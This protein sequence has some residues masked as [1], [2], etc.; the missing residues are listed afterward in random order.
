MFILFGVYFWAHLGSHSDHS[1]LKEGYEPRS[2]AVVIARKRDLAEPNPDQSS[3]L[4]QRLAHI[5]GQSVGR[6]GFLE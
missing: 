2:A 6:E 3:P 5:S 1:F 4:V